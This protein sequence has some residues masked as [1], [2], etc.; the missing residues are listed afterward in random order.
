V[1]VFVDP[2]GLT[3]YDPDHS[4]DEEPLIT[5]GLSVDDRPLLVVHTDRDQVIRIISAR[6]ATRQERK[7]YEDRDFP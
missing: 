5:M 1:T 3:G 2:P 7:D 4:D 6:E